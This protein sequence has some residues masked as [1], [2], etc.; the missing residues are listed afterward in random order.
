[1]AKRSSAEMQQ[2]SM[3]ESPVAP[4][5]DWWCML[6]CVHLVPLGVE[7]TTIKNTCCAA[8]DMNKL[9]PGASFL[10]KAVVAEG[11]LRIAVAA[12]ARHVTGAVFIPNQVNVIGWGP[13][14]SMVGTHW[15]RE[16][17]D[18]IRDVK[19]RA[20]SQ[21]SAQPVAVRIKTEHPS[22]TSSNTPMATTP[23]L[24]PLPSVTSLTAAKQTGKKT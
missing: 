19:K 18:V 23:R 1:M 4:G 14:T 15:H 5:E 12:D 10:D 8:V 20:T 9:F 13:L 24:Q 11:V 17:L 7:T 22:S 6:A 2:A 21:A 16:C 3:D